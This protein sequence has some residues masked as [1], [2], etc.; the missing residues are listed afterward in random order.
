MEYIKNTQKSVIVTGG[1][2]YVGHHLVNKLNNLGYQVFSTYKTRVD[3]TK[4]YGVV[5]VYVDL[6]D[7]EK[8]SQALGRADV[9]VHLAWDSRSKKQSQNIIQTSNLL[10]FM[11]T[12]HIPRI[13]FLSPIKSSRKAQN[14]FL[15][16]K[17]E[18]ESLIINSSLKEK[19]IVRSSSIFGGEFGR[20]GEFLNIVQN[21]MRS[22][23]FYP[24]PDK[25]AMISPVHVRDVSSL[26]QKLIEKPLNDPCSIL[27]LVGGKT[28]RVKDIFNF[29]SNVKLNGS[30]LPIGSFLGDMII[31]F[32]TRKSPKEA[33]RLKD[34]L[35]LGSRVNKTCGVNNPLFDC[36]PKGVENFEESI[37]GNRVSI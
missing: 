33:Q 14:N 31:R 5:P 37:K 18:A 3:T 6:N 30:R 34:H 7:K 29:I 26:L 15:K 22:S 25:D 1:S 10:S 4:H 36:I 11:K 23:L 35:S 19:I 17:Y 27:E 32:Y 8:L 2:G 12:H 28:Y 13:V 20:E 21:L 9:V 16:Q 24:L